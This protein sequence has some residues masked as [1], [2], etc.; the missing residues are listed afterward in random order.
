VLV[1][2]LQMLSHWVALLGWPSNVFFSRHR[3]FFS[4]PWHS[5]CWYS[6]PA[7]SLAVRGTYANSGGVRLYTWSFTIDGHRLILGC[8]L[9][10]GVRG[11]PEPRPV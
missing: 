11:T 6:N 9:N 5:Q 8:G 1:Q 3:H 4:R 7:F 2:G 10:R